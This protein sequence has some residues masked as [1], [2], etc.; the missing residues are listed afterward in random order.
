MFII[1]FLI[2]GILILVVQTTILQL[3]PVWLGKPDILFLLIVYISCQAD[4]LRGSVVI[5]LLG[6]LMDVFSGIFLGLYPV[7]YLLVFVFIKGISRKVAINEFAYQVPLAVISYLFVSIGMFLFFFSL[8]PETPPQ[9][10]WGTI[11]L[12]LLMLAVIGAPVFGILDSIMNV[13][14]SLSAS[15]RLPGSKSANRFRQ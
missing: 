9:W 4:I 5:L 2:L 6:L 8:A 13:Y 11:L 7:I 1:I 14:R 15:G 10:S 12:Q 3:L